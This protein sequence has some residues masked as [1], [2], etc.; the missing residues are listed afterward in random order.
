[1]I[2]EHAH[3]HGIHRSA[4]SGQGHAGRA[5][6][7]NLQDGPPLDRRHAPR[8]PRRQDGRR[9]KGRQ[10]H[11]FRGPGSRRNHHCDHRRAVGATGLPKGIPLGRLP[12]D[13]RT[14]RGARPDVGREGNSIG[15]R[16]GVA[17]CRGRVVPAAGR[18]RSGRRHAR[19]D[20]PAACGLPQANRTLA[21]ILRPTWS[22]E[23]H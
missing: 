11:V 10:V 12:A 13:D 16:S 21:A 6:G 18:S 2:Q 20:S 22:V 3:A 5:I 7:Q 15:C 23:E 17:G 9:R 14:G 1:M 8:R 4:R 19:C